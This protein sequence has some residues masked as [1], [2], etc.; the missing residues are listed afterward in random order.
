LT[1][2]I[3]L[4]PDDYY[5]FI[6]R[7]KLFLDKGKKA[8]AKKDF[9]RAAEI[10][11]DFFLAYV[12]LGDI[13]YED[14]NY[15]DARVAYEN[16]AARKPQYYFVYE[17]LGTIYYMEEKWLE[18][19]KAFSTAYT[20]ARDDHTYVLLAALCF[21]K[22]GQEKDAQAYITSQMNNIPQDSW[23]FD[24]ARF[25]YNPANDVYAL[26]RTDSEKSPIEKKRILFYIA[27]Q[28]LLSGK[29]KDTAVTYLLEAEN[30]ERKE[31]VECKLASL[32]LEKLQKE[33][34]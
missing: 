18:A 20:Y 28:Y 10:D 33:T 21:K 17:P 22:A 32:E 16:A 1:L 31:L 14:N 3:G 34:N 9:T 5:S 26:R 7:G 11:P 12:F 25:Y 23:Y 2:A 15:E 6:D 29:L 24:V 13:N 27:V 4:A 8:E 19:E 30:M